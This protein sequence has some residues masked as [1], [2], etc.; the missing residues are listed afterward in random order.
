MLSTSLTTSAQAETIGNKLTT[1][2]SVIDEVASLVFDSQSCPRNHDIEKQIPLWIIYEKADRENAGQDG[3]NIFDFIQKYYDW[4]YCDNETG[5]QYELSAAFTDIIDVQKTRTK[6]LERLSQ[7][8][9]P[10]FDVN[11]L[12]SNGGYVTELRLRNFLNGIKRAFYHK[13]TTEDSIRYF[14]KTLFGVQNEDVSI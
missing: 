10:G 4:L 14:F 2:A 6:F 9:A 5:A 11:S 8:Y 12:V 13:K 7:I 3:I 1:L